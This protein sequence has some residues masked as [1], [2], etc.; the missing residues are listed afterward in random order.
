MKV[1]G[2]ERGEEGREKG[3]G[4]GGGRILVA[5]RSVP[6]LHLLPH[7]QAP[8]AT[9][10]FCCERRHPNPPPPPFAVLLK[11]SFCRTENRRQLFL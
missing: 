4:G 3:E 11:H 6:V 8:G 7:E 5:K 9:C 1:E 10:I 2:E